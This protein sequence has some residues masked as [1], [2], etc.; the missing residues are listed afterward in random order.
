MIRNN[1]GLAKLALPSDQDASGRQ[2]AGEELR[3]VAAA[4]E[5]GTLTSTKG[6]FVKDLEGEF[7]EILSAKAVFACTSGT[8]ALHTTVAVIDPEPGDE[9]IT[10]PITDMRALAPILLMA[11]QTGATSLTRAHFWIWMTDE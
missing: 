4:L 3:N 6:N 8:A 7:A 1:D 11:R 9:I 10:T 2:F 5:S